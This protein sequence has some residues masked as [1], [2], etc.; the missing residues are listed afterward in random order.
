M[1]VDDLIDECC[2]IVIRSQGAKIPI[3]HIVDQ[4]LRTMEFTIDKVVGS[5]ARHHTTQTHMLYALEC[6]A[7]TV[8]NWS[9]GLLV[10]IKDHL[11]K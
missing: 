7:P 9:E 4:P 8:F 11:T 6:M 5:R 3:K 1:S 10:S 2:V